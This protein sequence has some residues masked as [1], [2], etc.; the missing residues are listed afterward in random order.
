M[1]DVHELAVYSAVDVVGYFCG[2]GMVGMILF[3][4]PRYYAILS[5]YLGAFGTALNLFL[6][7][8]FL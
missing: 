5:F 6:L 7:W 1:A 2:I 4:D 3:G 8:M